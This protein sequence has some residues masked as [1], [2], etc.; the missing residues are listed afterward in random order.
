MS[1][2]YR[3]DLFEIEDIA[4]EEGSVEIKR[5]DFEGLLVAPSDWTIESLYRQIG[6]QIDLDR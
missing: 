5:G 4:F 1:Q 6:K 3:D 2:F